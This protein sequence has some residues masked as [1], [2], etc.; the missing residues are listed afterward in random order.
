MA[1]MHVMCGVSP[2]Q[3]SVARLVRI[4]QFQ[5]KKYT[6]RLLTAASVFADYKGRLISIYGPITFWYI[7][8]EHIW[9]FT[10]L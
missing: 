10:L 4:A 6:C 9:A 7:V 2:E 5:F 1:C 8:A 3:A